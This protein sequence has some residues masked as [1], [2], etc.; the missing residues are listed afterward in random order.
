M[1]LAK[2]LNKRFEG[3][4]FTL[5]QAYEA[6]PDKP[7]ETVRARIY[8]NLGIY[9]EKLG[10]GVY[11][12]TL[13]NDKCVLIN[14]DGR[15]LSMINDSSIDCIVTDHPWECPSNKGGNRDFSEYN[16]FK[17][18]I[19]DFKEKARV[20]KEGSFLIEVLPAENE[21]NYEYLY[22][23]KKMAKECGF[24]YYA[25]VP[26]RKGTFVSNTGRKAKNTEELLIF[27]KGKARN[28]RLDSKRSTDNNP[29]YM[30]GT[31]GMLPTEFNIQSLTLKEKINQSEKPI[32]LWI[33]LIPYVTKE[34]ERILDQFAGSCNVGLAALSLN[35]TSVMIEK[36][37]N[38]L[39]KVVKRV[40]KI[41]HDDNDIK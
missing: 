2:S 5:K 25:K 13:G 24:K 1:S 37:L 16:T 14:G 39:L 17:Y 32:E 4:E 12:A 18:S 26:W 36:D 8:D 40:N 6:I 19:E 3:S 21:S 10:R 23:I 20:L 41:V 35:R 28:L 27:S 22:N 15:D 9:F 38:S 34:H 31:N 29:V 30:S 33:E 7:K 11:R